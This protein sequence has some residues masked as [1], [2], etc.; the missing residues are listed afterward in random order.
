MATKRDFKLVYGN[1]PE[2]KGKKRAS[3]K[4]KKGAW[5]GKKG[6]YGSGNIGFLIFLLI[7]ALTV[8]AGLYVISRFRVENITVEGNVHYSQEEIV[9]MVLTD[10]LSY[11]SLYLSF[12]YRNRPIRDIPFIETMSVSVVSPDTI[13]IIVYEKSVAGYVD[14]MGR[15]MYFDRD[16]IVVESSETRTLGIPQVTGI[17]FDHVVLYEPLPVEDPSI[18]AQILSITQVLSKYD[19]MT[20]KIYFNESNQIT[21]YFG[22]VRAR[23][24]SDNLEEKVMRLQ[25]ILPHLES[26]SGVLDM[27]NYTEESQNIT[28]T[29][30]GN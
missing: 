5:S 14:Y 29:Q 10:P 1:K 20:D 18:F 19:I 17:T 26:E 6:T 2:K 8:G 4:K 22:K 28:F 23:L 9:D 25:Y 13:K 21:L 24:G 11:N 30:D 15:F 27:E 7:L 16:G 3:G 12:K